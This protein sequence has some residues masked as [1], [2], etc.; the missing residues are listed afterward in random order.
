[1]SVAFFPGKFQPVHL[2][3]IITIMGLY[4]QYDK[5]IIGITEDIPEIIS[6]RE[7]K[8]IFEKVLKHLPKFEVV[9]IKGTIVNSTSP[10]NL[11]EFDVCLTG[12]SEVISKLKEYGIKSKLIER[13]KGVAY[14]GTEIRKLYNS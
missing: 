2:G 8:D 12:N 13:S 5:I 6:Q 1:M 10:S 4:D 14:S 7:R 3:H 9:L 11:P